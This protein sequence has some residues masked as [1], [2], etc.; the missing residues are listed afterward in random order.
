[1][2]LSP[3]G[4]SAKTLEKARPISR[5]AKTVL[6]LPVGPAARPGTATGL[7]RFVWIAPSHSKQGLPIHGCIHVAGPTQ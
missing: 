6:A 4:A 5:N 7:Q 1:M 3:S 2:L